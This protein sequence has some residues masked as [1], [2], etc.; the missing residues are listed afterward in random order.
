MKIRLIILLGFWGTFL[1]AQSQPG[2]QVKNVAI[3]IHQGVELFDFAGPGEVFVAASR[4]SPAI[5]FNVYTVAVDL[6]QI[7]SQ[8]FL[9]V[10][11]N[12][13]LDNCPTP[14]IIILPGG[15]TSIPLKDERVIS[16]IQKAH[17]QADVTLS[18]CTGA[19]L[20]GKANLLTGLKATTHWGSIESLR[21]QYPDTEVLENI[22]FV[23]NGSIITSGGVSSG[24]EGSLHLVSRIAGKQTA[25]GVARYMEYGNWDARK[26]LVVNEDR[27]QNLIKHVGLEELINNHKHHGLFY[28]EFFNLGTK[29]LAQERIEEARVLWENLVE[30]FPIIEVY[31]QLGITLR[32]LG[33]KAPPNTE[34]LA[35][36]ISAGKMDEARKIYEVSQKEFPHW[37][38]LDEGQM[39]RQGYR[40]LS[41]GKY[42]AAIQVFLLNTEEFPH[43]FNTWDSLAE[44]YLKSGDQELARKY[45]K[46]SLELNPE[47]TNA[48][49]ILATMNEKSQ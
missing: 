9:K 34:D 35:A 18:V 14:D 23:D 13:T 43:S 16:W 40:F 48:L 24:T 49:E 20:L 33:E 30:Q 3:F 47:N 27:L 5:D 37:P 32:L 21:R 11:P 6:Q 17:M 26:G 41:A 2:Q 38:L 12:Y 19:F 29:Y 28:G 44:G 15:A 4:Q 31:D 45:Y 25:S 39:N 46:K 7:T 22:K 8:T 1:S 10:I 42:E 36:L